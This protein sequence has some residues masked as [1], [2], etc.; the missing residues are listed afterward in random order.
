MLLISTI[1]LG[2]S[3][4]LLFMPPEGMSDT[5]VYMANGFRGTRSVQL[6]FLPNTNLS[7]GAELIQ[8]FEDRTKIF[9]Y[10]AFI[11][12]MSVAVAYGLITAYFFRT[13][14]D[15]DP[16]F[17]NPAGYPQMAISF[18]CVMILAILT[19]AFGTRDQIPH[20]RQSEPVSR[21]SLST[22]FTEMWSV[23][24][25][26]SFR[27]VFLGTLFASVIAG[28]ESAFTPSWVYILGLSNRGPG[29]SRLRWVVWFSHNL[30]PDPKIVRYLGRR[31]AVVVPLTLWTLAINI[32]ISMRL[33]DAPWFLQTTRSGC[34]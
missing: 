13:T 9:A 20:L 26:S 6:D 24:K 23:L 7:L 19:C 31:M 16:G 25:N 18:A 17:L 22:V 21:F 29:L 14:E 1:P 15:Y 4:A 34:S 27:A 8:T 33:L 2:I 12:A 30:L 11:Q 5:Q 32:P 3:F 10:S 28:I